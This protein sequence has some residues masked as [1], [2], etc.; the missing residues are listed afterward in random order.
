MMSMALVEEDVQLLRQR[1]SQ[2]PEPVFNE[3]LRTNPTN[4]D[5]CMSQLYQ[6][7]LV[8][9]QPYP[10]CGASAGMD[11]AHRHQ[12]PID[13]GSDTNSLVSTQNS[14]GWVRVDWP[15]TM[16]P[17]GDTTVNHPHPSNRTPEAAEPSSGWQGYRQLYHYPPPVQVSKLSVNLRG[18][19]RNP[20]S[21]TAQAQS[22]DTSPVRTYGRGSGNTTPGTPDSSGL[23]RSISLHGVSPPMDRS[24]S[25]S[26]NPFFPGP[27]INDYALRASQSNG[28]LDFQEGRSSP[29][30]AYLAQNSASSRPS[31]GMLTTSPSTLAPAAYNSNS[32]GV[33]PTAAVVQPN[34]VSSHPVAPHQLNNPSPDVRRRT[35]T[36]PTDSV[37]WAD[38]ASQRHPDMYSATP[39]GP[40]S[41]AQ[42]LGHTSYATT[43]PPPHQ[44]TAPQAM[45]SPEGRK[46]MGSQDEA[47]Y[48]Q[49]L[50]MHQRARKDR[51]GR[52]LSQ[53]QR[54]LEL[55]RGE[56]GTMEQD[57][58][59]KRTQNK[60][61]LISHDQLNKLREEK[62]QLQIDIECMNNEI[63]QFKKQAVISIGNQRVHF[64]ENMGTTGRND[65]IPPAPIASGQAFDVQPLFS[66]PD[67]GQQWSCTHC[68]FLNHPFL[69]KCECCEMPRD[70]P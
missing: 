27:P 1:F 59:N 15:T 3:C 65:P 32:V 35:P 43:S 34:V 58:N 57:L 38:P 24:P 67:E 4:L 49:A 14:D 28:R 46:R 62:R 41:S 8:A 48:N 17:G 13:T 29:G 22:L 55:L 26:I 66:D 6:Q 23:D 31:H 20:S 68:T 33:L 19:G 37:R 69:D 52:D 44:R 9:A 2:L 7:S 16:H 18:E 53:E 25:P 10:M 12:Q 42:M 64:Y 5:Q 60:A 21:N 47:A 30:V 36:H 45:E 39:A 11:P 61:T 40:G 51:L 54:K 56:I 70:N 63:E 50:I